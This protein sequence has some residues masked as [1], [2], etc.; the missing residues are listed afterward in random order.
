MSGAVRG[1]GR[2]SVSERV[3]R[4]RGRTG[5]VY[6]FLIS[7]SPFRKERRA[8]ESGVPFCSLACSVSCFWSH[9]LLDYL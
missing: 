1:E 6:R 2:G 5:G 3:R 8:S 7:M 9:V 4:A